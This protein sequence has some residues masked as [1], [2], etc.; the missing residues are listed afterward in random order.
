[1]Y[2]LEDNMEGLVLSSHR[3]ASR[4]RAVVVR[5]GGNAYW[6]VHCAI[7]LFLF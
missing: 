4:D 3:V 6:Y 1:M 2:E 5:L 7:F